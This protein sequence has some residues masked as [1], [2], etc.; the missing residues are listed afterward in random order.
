MQKR[1]DMRR[2]DW[3]RILKRDYVAERCTFQGV[4]GIASLIMIREITQPLTVRNGDHD[5]TIVDRGMSWVQ[6][7]LQDQYVW[8]TV[9]FDRQGRLLQLYFDITNGNCL[10]PADN[11]TFEDLYLDIVMEP[12]GS[13]YVLDRNELDEAFKAGKITAEQY[14]RTVAEGERLYKWLQEHGQAFAAFGCEQRMKLKGL[15]ENGQVSAR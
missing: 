15:L 1:R 8:A 11:P 6:V 2:T 3:K 5:V 13:L 12:D 4:E 14:E 10:E 9:M 7:A